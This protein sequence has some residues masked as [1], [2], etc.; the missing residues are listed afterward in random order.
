MLEV[1]AIVDRHPRLEVRELNESRLRF[2]PEALQLDHALAGGANR[3]ALQPEKDEGA[4]Q[5]KNQN[6]ENNDGRPAQPPPVF[7]GRGA[8]VL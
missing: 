6:D 5:R 1:D 3:P 7:P 8:V 2:T 4:E